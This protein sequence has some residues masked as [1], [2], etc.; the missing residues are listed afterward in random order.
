MTEALLCNFNYLSNS[1]C[2][3]K[4]LGIVKIKEAMVMF[5]TVH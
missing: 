5:L 3:I 1:D 2:V 4:F